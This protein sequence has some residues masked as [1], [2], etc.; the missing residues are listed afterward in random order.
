MLLQADGPCLLGHETVGEEGPPRL[1]RDLGEHRATHVIA[2][3]REDGRAAKPDVGWLG[4]LLLPGVG[5]PGLSCDRS[6]RVSSAASVVVRQTQGAG[7]RDGTI[8]VR[9]PVPATAVAT[10][11]HADPFVGESLSPC[12]RAGCG[13]SARPV[14]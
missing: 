7:T 12:P 1:R 10:A 13:K 4:E 14:R 5:Q 3:S 9:T 6:A 8:L 11:W 2:V